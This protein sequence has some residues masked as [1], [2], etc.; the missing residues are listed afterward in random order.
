ME[1]TSSTTPEGIV[2]CLTGRLEFT[3][4]DRLRDIV[5]LLNEPGLR[6]FVIDLANLEFIDS[7]GIGMLL[8]LL[9]EAE[10]RNIRFMVRGA[11]DT[12]KR[13]LDLAKIGEILTLEN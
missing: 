12:V 5:A 11:R 10:Q 8:I 4:H 9:E 6:T 1:F 2:A 3:D 13:S 7:A